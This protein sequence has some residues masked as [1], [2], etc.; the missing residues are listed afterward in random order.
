MRPVRAEVD[1]EAVAANVSTLR[2]AVGHTRFCAVVKANGYG[3]GAV[4][5]AQA[6]IAGGADLLGVALVAEGVELRDAQISQPIIVLSQAS[7]DEIDV[8]VDQDLDATVYTE[9]GARALAEAVNAAGPDESRTVP[10]HLKVDTGMHRVGAQPAEVVELAR[11]IVAEPRLRLASIFTHCAVAD[12]P[13]NAFTDQQRAVFTSVLADLADAGIEVPCRH[14]ANSAAA[15]AW[16]DTRYD[17]VRCGIAIYGLSPSPA[18][19]GRVDL[20]P[21]MSLRSEVA[22]VKRVVAGE[23][24]SYG[25]R[26]RP[27]RDV[28]IATVP[29]GYADG[30]ARRLSSLGGEVLIGGRRRPIAGTITMDQLMVDC[31]EDDVSVG[32]EVVLIG[33]QGDEAITADE[34]ADRLGTISYEVVC[35]IGPRVPRHYGV[36]G[37]LGDSR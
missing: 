5:V 3:H 19:A 31:G 6:A 16:P 18:L 10:V 30:V 12:E 33:R 4:P 9:A 17:M 24:L 35:A 36:A 26:Y 15:I 13:D 20:R 23:G 29:L 27:D 11:L 37:A 21:A 28:T 34:W 8:L 2:A 14:M 7:P 1:L 25:L 22:H 32:D